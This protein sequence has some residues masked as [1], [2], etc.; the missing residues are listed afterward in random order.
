MR[1]PSIRVILTSVC[2]ACTPALAQS[3]AARGSAT[4]VLEPGDL[5]RITV[6]R[7]PELSGD[8]LVAAD[9][10]L[11]HPLYRDV[12]IAGLPL[13]AAHARLQEF[14]K[15][16]EASPQLVLEPLFRVTVG[17][18]VRNPNLYSLAP[19]TTIS[20]AVALAGGPTERGRLDQVRVLRGGRELRVNLT[21]AGAQ[22]TQMPIVS[23]D[24]IFVV[25]QRSVFR[26][27]ILPAAS[28]VGAAA[29]IA[30]LFIRR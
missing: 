28:V 9:S 27:V 10:T 17:G 6:W 18:E 19:E 14:L 20:Q 12:K 5:V 29:A 30:G 11:K 13:P 23:G 16:F 8:I 24:Q 25:R 21:S 1:R 15:Q 7:K 22:G 3:S 4:I 2:L 26:D